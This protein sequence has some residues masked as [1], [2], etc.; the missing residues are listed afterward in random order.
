MNETRHR[1]PPFSPVLLAGLAVRPLPLALLRPFASAAMAATR[2]G[3]P[4]VFERLSDLGDAAFLIDP[5]DLPF[6]FILRPGL[7]TPTLAPTADGED[8]GPVA[9][10]IRGPLDA[11]IDLLEGRLDGDAL[12]FSR[13]LDIE[14]DT[15]A[16]LTLRNAVDSAEIDVLEDLLA[17]L[18][19]LRRPARLAVSLGGA[20][21]GR[22]ASDLAILRDAI[23]APVARRC[24][25]QAADLGALEEAL[26]T[27]RRE[28]RRARPAGRRAAETEAGE[29]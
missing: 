5:V 12:F 15:E 17:I 20:V 21:L 26:T 22:A 18:G 3:H 25:L 2:R 10:T 16:V 27:L 8:A 6:G 23:V 24:E 4:E 13:E 1:V 7:P 11:L 9:A 14:G 19:P 28:V 29:T